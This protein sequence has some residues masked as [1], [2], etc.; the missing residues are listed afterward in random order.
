[1][2]YNIKI[3]KLKTSQDCLSCAYF[4]KFHKSCG[5]HGKVCFEYD[6]KTNKI[7]DPITKKTIT[8]KEN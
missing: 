8:I 5:G 4:D 1:M 7:V 3:K 6:K 2:L